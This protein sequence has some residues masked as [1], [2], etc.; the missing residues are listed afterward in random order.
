MVDILAVGIF[1]NELVREGAIRVGWE[2]EGVGWGEM[3]FIL[4]NGKFKVDTE[5]MSKK[6]VKEVL[7]AL[8]EDM[9]VI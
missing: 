3:D 2:K 8:Y 9:E 1:K 7:D 4:E 6:F 5:H